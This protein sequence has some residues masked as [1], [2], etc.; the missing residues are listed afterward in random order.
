MEQKKTQLDSL[1]GNQNQEVI[2]LK[3]ELHENVIP[4]AISPGETVASIAQRYNMESYQDLLI[5]NQSL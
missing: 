3:Q 5:L 1:L 4:H 2:K